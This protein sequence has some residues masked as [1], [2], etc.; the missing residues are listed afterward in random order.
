MA[1]NDA[2]GDALTYALSGTDAASFDIDLATGQLM[3]LDALDYETKSSYSV[4]VTASDSGGLSG[5]HRRNGD[6]HQR[7]RAGGGVPVDDAA[8]GRH[9]GNCHLGDPDGMET[10]EV[11]QW[12]RSMDGTT[13]MD[14]A[15]A[16]MY[17]YSPVAMDEG[18]Y[19]R[20]MVM[21]TDGHGSGKEAMGAS[22]NEVALG[23][24]GSLSVDYPENDM[25]SVATYTASGF[26]ANMTNWSVEGDDASA[27]SIS[28]GGMLMFR[29]SPD[30]ENPM[31][32][33]MDNMY[34]VTVKASDGTRMDT[35]DVMV[36]V[37]NVDEDGVV[38]LSGMNPVAGTMVTAMLED[39]DGTVSGEMWQWAKSMDMD[40]TFMDIG[41]ASTTY[42]PTFDDVD[43]YLRATV[44][45]TDGHGSG[46][47]A[48]GLS[49]NKVLASGVSVTGLSSVD[50]EENGV[51]SV[52]TYVA[53]GLDADTA[54]WSLVGVDEGDFDI[55]GDGVLTFKE[56]PNFENAVDM[57]TD[58]TYMVTVKANVGTYMD[59]LDVMVMVTDVD[60]TPVI[61]GDAAPNYAEN[62]TNPVATY[63]ATDPENATITWT[64]EGDDTALFQLSSGGVLTFGSAPDY[65]NP[66][67]TGMDNVYM[68]TIMAS[69]GT[70]MDTHDVMVTVT[71]VD[72]AEAGDPLLAEYDGDGD[73]SINL[74]EARV[75][76]GDYFAQPKGEKLSLADTRKVVG[77]YFAYKNRQ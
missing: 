71:D 22:A 36:E 56:S 20:A 69:D 40:G 21:Y 48:V 28:S 37:T 52:A 34:M 11:W 4:T 46:K 16:T 18:Y 62:G 50:Y 42:T 41:G 47:E 6:G 72:D 23:V 60:E 7:G 39:P 63:T 49:A 67:D 55:S 59:T 70:N 53:S 8:R 9:G 44:M 68:V 2:N 17:T 5:L 32:I 65:E 24:T 51:G 19:L 1:A 10:D 64:L 29:Q 31:D 12:A 27:F 76:V 13:F 57:D 73:G 77:L 61:T 43:Y 14:I 30:Y 74:E 54:T 33:G 58:N 45:Y 66:T 25:G 15:E 35:H 75:A 3:T 38:T 26:D